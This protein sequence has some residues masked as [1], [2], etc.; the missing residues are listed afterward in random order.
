MRLSQLIT[1]LL[2]LCMLGVTQSLIGAE[3][4]TPG[5]DEPGKDEPTIPLA[6]QVFRVELQAPLSTHF[7]IPQWPQNA[8]SFRLQARIRLADDIPADF[9]LGIWLSNN[10]GHWQQ[11]IPQII[12]NNGVIELDVALHKDAWFQAQGQHLPWSA[13]QLAEAVRGGLFF[14]SEHNSQGIVTID[15]IRIIP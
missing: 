5:K 11:K 7:H 9:G 1:Q 12:N 3:E 10:D 6:E 2:F 13:S 4:N 15:N 8:S 14:W